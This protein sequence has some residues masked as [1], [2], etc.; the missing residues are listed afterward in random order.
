MPQRKEW[1]EGAGPM[2]GGSGVSCIW[3]Q[4]QKGGLGKEGGKR[5]DEG[6]H[7]RGCLSS[8]GEGV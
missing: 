8:G 7:E 3:V 4:G 5:G 2:R 1:L 6:M